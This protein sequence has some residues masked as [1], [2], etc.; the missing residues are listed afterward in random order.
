MK[1][2]FLHRKCLNGFLKQMVCDK[3]AHL[4]IVANC[5]SY[6]CA[7]AS[8]YVNYSG[9]NDYFNGGKKSL[10]VCKKILWPYLE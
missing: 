7:F 2:M 9:K 4:Q 5:V 6:I 1:N 10:P 8:F 3:K